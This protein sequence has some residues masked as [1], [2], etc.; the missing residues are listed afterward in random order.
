LCGCSTKVEIT[1]FSDEAFVEKNLPVFINT[2]NSSYPLLT[3]ALKT[4]LEKQIKK[5]GFSIDEQNA[6]YYLDFEL[7]SHDK[8]AY[9]RYEPVYNYSHVRCNSNKEC[10]TVPVITYIPCLDISESIYVVVNASDKNTNETKE[11][12]IINKSFSDNCYYG[13]R[14]SNSF[15]HD[16]FLN[17]SIDRENIK[18]VAAKIKQSIFPVKTIQKEK[19]LDE[20]KSINL[21]QSEMEAFKKSYEFASKRSYKEAILGFENLKESIS[22]KIPYEIYFNLGLLYEHENDLDK[23]LQ[24]YQSISN[25]QNHTKRVYIKKR[26]EKK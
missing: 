20:V 22:D 26:Y 13:F 7:I 14:F 16:M 1:S 18:I 23:A 21:S 19:L 6:S 8:F 2:K 4:E 12:P 3:Q 10:Y 5:D 17:D 15:H 25:A 11:F 9:R 24:N